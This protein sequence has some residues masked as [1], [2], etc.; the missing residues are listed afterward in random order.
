MILKLIVVFDANTKFPSG[1]LA[2]NFY[3]LGNFDECLN[4]TSTEVLG[5]YCLGTIPVDPNGLATA[6]L[7]SPEISDFCKLKLSGV[8]QRWTSTN[9]RQRPSVLR[10]SFCRVHSSQVHRRRRHKNLSPHDFWREVLLQQRDA[11]KARRWSNCNNVTF[12]TV[13]FVV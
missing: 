7:V 6:K 11:A 2:G 5:K 3:D 8:D 1:L 13:S 4:V 12:P 9:V 10:S